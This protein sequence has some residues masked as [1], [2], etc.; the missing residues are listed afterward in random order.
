MYSL[1]VSGSVKKFIAKRTPKEQL[2][3]I[4]AF[5]ALQKDPFSNTLDIKPFKSANGNEY[6]LRIRDYRF[7]YRVIHDDVFIYVFKSGNRGEVYK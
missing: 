3:I 4:R 6:R 5:E 1:D 2:T 7:I